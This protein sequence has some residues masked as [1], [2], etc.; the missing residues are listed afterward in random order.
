MAVDFILE[1]EGV[2]GEC[3]KQGY[4]GKIDIDSWSGSA[5]RSGA[6][7]IG[8][9]GTTGA[10]SIS[11]IGISKHFDKASCPL[12]LCVLTGKH[13]PSGK[14]YCRKSIGDKQDV[15]LQIDLTDIVVTSYSA[16]GAGG[17]DMI[18][19]NATF[20][21]AKMEIKYKEQSLDGSLADAGELK[22]DV[23]K[24]ETF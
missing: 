24:G 22:F 21:F 3:Q 23:P 20:N 17:S 14:I 13:I 5:H 12:E 7:A 11:D 19:E 9:G 1:L 8:G 6:F 10:A 18:H 2:P 15:Y 4:E 16:G